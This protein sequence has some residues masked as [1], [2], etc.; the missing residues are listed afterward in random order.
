MITTLNHSNSSVSQQIR[1]VFQA[2]YAIEAELLGAKEFPPLKRP[3]EKFIN[4]ETQFLGYLENHELAAVIE[5]EHD[6]GSTHINSL[7]V[8]PDHFRKGIGRKL[9]QHV[10]DTFDSSLYTV[11]TGVD[12]GPATTLY[13]KMGFEEVEVFD[14]PIGI[15]KVRFEKRV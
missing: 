10:F 7:V 6:R 5:I 1:D 14:T 8:H 9:V 4:S 11:E 12:N 13:L 3:L 15:K 2:S